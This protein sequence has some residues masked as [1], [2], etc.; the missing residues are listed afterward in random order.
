METEQNINNII[1]R[2]LENHDAEL[3]HLKRTSIALDRY[4]KE[5]KEFSVLIA[6]FFAAIPYSAPKETAIALLEQTKAM[7]EA[8]IQV[9]E[10]QDEIAS[11]L[12]RHKDIL[13]ELSEEMRK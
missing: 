13:R 2:M 1:A 8:V 12:T 9:A 4:T 6:D 10:A 3:T 5:L 7:L 11:D